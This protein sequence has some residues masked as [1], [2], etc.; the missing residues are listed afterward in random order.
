MQ[1]FQILN[2]ISS[3]CPVVIFDI[4]GIRIDAATSKKDLK[5]KYFEEEVLEIAAG[6]YSD[7]LPVSAIFIQIQH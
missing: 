4:N 1:L 7:Q 6:K 2:F 5:I 3:N